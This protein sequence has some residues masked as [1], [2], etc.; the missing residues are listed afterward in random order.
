MCAHICV[1]MMILLMQNN[2]DGISFKKSRRSDNHFIG[3]HFC[4][5]ICYQS[6]RR[7]GYFFY[8]PFTVR[9]LDAYV[10]LRL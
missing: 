10:N 8:L 3:Q 2:K 6:T 7:K 4:L 9:N 1:N 5:D